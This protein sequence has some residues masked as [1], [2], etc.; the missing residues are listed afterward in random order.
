M[1]CI[2]GAKKLSQNL[3]SWISVHIIR[4]IYY[5]LNFSCHRVLHRSRDESTPDCPHC[6][7]QLWQGYTGL[8]S[9]LLQQWPKGALQT[10]TL[11]SNFHYV[12][13][14][15]RT[16]TAASVSSAILA[17]CWLSWKSQFIWRIFI[18]RSTSKLEKLSP[19]TSCFLW[20]SIHAY[21]NLHNLYLII[22]NF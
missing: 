22:L 7:G 3:D 2:Y 5:K 4:G 16:D 21:K 15:R 20:V 18:S 17:H 13:I 14:A 19:N 6:E 12:N 9:S 11:I 8:H 1:D 10:M